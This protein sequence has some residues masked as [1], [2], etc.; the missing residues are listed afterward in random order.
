M[1]IL[2][3]TA[4]R[5]GLAKLDLFFP[6]CHSLKEK[7]HLLLKIKNRISADFK[8]SVH[9]V[10]SH[11]KWQRAQIGLAVVGNDAAHLSSLIDK[12]VEKISLMGVGEVIDSCSEIIEF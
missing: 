10:S 5:V 7:R 4:M 9:E 6:F 8:V 3:D 1:N 2:Q 11:D 12:V